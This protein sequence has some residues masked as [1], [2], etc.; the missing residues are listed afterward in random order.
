MT[1]PEVDRCGWFAAAEAKSL[2]NPSQAELIDRLES[3][4][5]ALGAARR[6][7]ERHQEMGA[8]DHA[9]GVVDRDHAA[10][11]ARGLP[12]LGLGGGEGNRSTI[13]AHCSSVRSEG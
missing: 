9:F 13:S 1:Y 2:I 10:F 4:V 12:P 7:S 6:A 5:R 8:V 11:A 3:T